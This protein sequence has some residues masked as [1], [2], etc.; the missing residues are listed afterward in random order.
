MKS[1][2]HCLS[3]SA[4]APILSA[5]VALFLIAQPG[6]SHADDHES[7]SWSI[8]ESGFFRVDTDGLGTQFWFGANHNLGGIN[9]ATDV[10]LVGTFAELDVGVSFTFG[11]VSL[12]P[13]VGIGFDF[14]GD[15]LAA[16]TLIAPQLYTI[17]DIGPIYFESWI[18]TFIYDDDRSGAQDALYTRNFLLYKAAEGFAIGPQVELN[19]G[20]A[21]SEPGADDSGELT[22]LAIGGRINVHYGE[23]NTLGLFIGTDTE[24]ELTNADG[25]DLFEWVGRFTF[26]RNW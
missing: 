12:L 18:Q 19:V 22:S 7:S 1:V 3:S 16:N 20:L 14:A 24:A 5:A 6:T 15:V 9:L 25:D 4:L 8:A 26:V 21:D 17:V 10:Y 2:H 23:N 13:M 11:D